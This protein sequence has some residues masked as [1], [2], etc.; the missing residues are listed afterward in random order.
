MTKP[1]IVFFGYDTVPKPTPK[2]FLRTLLYS[3][4]TRGQVIEG[5]RVI[6]RYEGGE[7]VFSFW[8]LW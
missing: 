4:A 3:T 7:R 6:V 8:G 2:V 5:M 1:T